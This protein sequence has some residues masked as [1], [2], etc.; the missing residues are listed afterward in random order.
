M[1]IE[2]SVI[3]PVYNVEEYLP[4]CLDSI[5]NQTF[6]DFELILIDDGSTDGSGRICD[7]YAIIDNRIKVF[8]KR[9]EGQAIAK[10]FGIDNSLGKYISF[11]DSDDWIDE[12]MLLEMYQEAISNDADIVIA[13]HYVVN[14]DNTIECINILNKRKLNR[15]EATKLI[16]EDTQILSFPWDKIYRRELFD[17][18]KYSEKRIFEDT[19]TTY[20]LFNKANVLVQLN[21][22]YYYYVRRESGTCLD[23]EFSKVIKRKMDNYLA[24]QERY[25]FTLANKEYADVIHDCQAKAFIH[26][27]QFLHFI[28]KNKLDTSLNSFESILKKLSEMKISNNSFLSRSNKIEHQI[29]KMSPSVYS[30]FLNSYYF[31]KS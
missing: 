9:N 18:I 7:E 4:K 23:P 30:V 29:M 14:L 20:K 21:Q 28:I 22:S 6:K 25:E 27:Q 12:N 17:G 3:V 5:L 13:G 11:V 24:F 31:F 8:H 16:L 10:N 19:A 1:N 26:G 15:L 2:I